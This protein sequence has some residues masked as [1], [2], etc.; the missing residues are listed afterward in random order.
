MTCTAELRHAERNLS[1]HERGAESGVDDSE[2]RLELVELEEAQNAEPAT[3]FNVE[4]HKRV[5]DIK[6]HKNVS[7]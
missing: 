1:T 6:R 5:F 4:C 7:I 2:S 3:R